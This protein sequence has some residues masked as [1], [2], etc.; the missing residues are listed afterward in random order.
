M[1]FSIS[2][3]LASQSMFV[4]LQKNE[5]E[6]ESALEQLNSGIRINSAADDPAGLVASNALKVEASSFG[7]ALKNTNEGISLLQIAENAVSKQ[8]K[9]AESIKVIAIKA[10][11]DS[12][13]LS[14]RNVLHSQAMELMEEFNAIAKNTSYNTHSLLQGSYT[15]KYVQVGAHSNQ[16]HI[17]N[18]GDTKSPEPK[19]FGYSV[20]DS[21]SYHN[22]AV[23]SQDIEVGFN[24][25]G[26]DVSL[27]TAR[28]GT[29]Q[30]EG[31][32]E[33]AKL[34]NNSTDTT[35]IYA[36]ADVTYVADTNLS[37]RPLDII[38]ASTTP[39]NFAINGVVIGSVNVLE[40]DSDNAL[41]DAINTVENQT[42][43]HASLN[44]E[45]QLLLT[46]ADARAISVTP[47]HAAT[48]SVGDVDNY[49]G[50]LKLKSTN[51]ASIVLS[52]AF[53]NGLDAL[54]LGHGA[55]ITTGL[56]GADETHF[57]K[58]IAQINLTGELDLS[59]GFP[60]MDA[61]EILSDSL[62]AIDALL[63]KLH[64]VNSDIGA[65][66]QKFLATAENVQNMQTISTVAYSRMTDIDFAEETYA[67]TKASIL[68]KAGNFV[69][70]HANIQ[71]GNVMKLLLGD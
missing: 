22:R 14:D 27:G 33:V 32:G 5:N 2:T 17:I 16:T 28:I 19:S 37:Q 55:D 50:I 8:I 52:S 59:D 13:S 35:D 43:V 68:S 57:S 67:F 21:Q 1:S 40:G 45:R 53:K 61:E 60:L 62:D 7:A 9:L 47:H 4:N 31:L 34:I 44:S 63:E 18:I 51:S 11:Q 42:G 6:L 41:Q 24:I 12:S 64:G 36:L 39:S 25:E 48:D 69:V 46:S 58:S 38:G 54:N 30:N 23:L 56:G 65:Q 66:E 10:A 71:Q 29:A 15:N 70:A 26:E 3:S 20:Y 49:I